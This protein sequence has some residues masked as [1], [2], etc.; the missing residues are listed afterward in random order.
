MKRTRTILT[1]VMV[2]AVAAIGVASPL[3]ALEPDLP[4]LLTVDALASRATDYAG[5]T[6]VLHGFVDR[7]SSQR[8]MFT[9]IDPSEANC[10]AACHRNI[11]VASVPAGVEAPLPE[12]RKEVLVHGSV[13][14]A[15]THLRLAVTRIV[16]DAA[17]VKDALASGRER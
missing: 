5:R 11:V 8:G 6:V 4:P 14:V 7:V 10:T 17:Q 12:A 9:L 16:S 1:A 13:D 15:G 2:A 3:A